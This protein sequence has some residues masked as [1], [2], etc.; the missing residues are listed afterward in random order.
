[1]ATV[2]NQRKEH[3]VTDTIE[4]I[5]RLKALAAWRRLNAEHAGRAWVWDVRLRTAEDL[6]RRAA[7]L[8]VRRVHDHRSAHVRQAEGQLA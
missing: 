7:E 2:T 6:Q 1:L 5:N 8:R 4:S 3:G